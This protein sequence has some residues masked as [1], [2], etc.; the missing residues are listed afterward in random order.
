MMHPY[1]CA[2]ARRLRRCE[3]GRAGWLLTH[4]L[5]S[6]L[7][8]SARKSPHVRVRLVLPCFQVGLDTLLIG[9]GGAVG[10]DIGLT[11]PEWHFAVVR[12][13]HVAAL[14]FQPLHS[15]LNEFLLRAFGDPRE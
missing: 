14:I 12:T 15:L 13:R 11:R 9:H 10:G 1:G 7:S 2:V 5:A 8:P 4:A 6:P 3:A